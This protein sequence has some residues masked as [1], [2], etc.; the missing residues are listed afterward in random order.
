MKLIRPTAITDAA[1]TSSD[2][3][4]PESG[5]PTWLIGTTY[6]VGDHVTKGHRRYES[7][8]SSNVGH[9]PTS[10]ASGD[11]G[12]WNDLGP[13]NRWAMFD[14]SVGTET[15]STGSINVVLE[16]GTV[17]SLVVLDT[18]A[19][20]VTVSMTV[21]GS[22]V[23]ESEQTTNVGGAAI[24]DWFLYFFEPIGTKDTLSFTDLPPYASGVITVAITGRDPMGPVHV[25][26]LI[27]GR[28]L[29]IGSTEVGG[30]VGIT[31]YSK[32]VTDDFG[33]TT[34][35][36]RA[37][38][39]RMD[40]TCMLDTANVDAIQRELAKVRAVP[41][42]WIGEEGFDSLTIYG[43]YKDFSLNLTYSNISYCSLT[44]EGLT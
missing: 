31:D 8:V 1:L 35:V 26:T 6:A 16:P 25:G 17:D 41:C 19:E 12:K 11:I 15:T 3:A 22:P 13:T 4:E 32:K 21:S 20:V 36:E 2:Q 23:Y 39:K 42:I 7:L 10:T 18:D 29:E 43:F 5:Y 24:I 27:V 34:V 33:V 30:S 28:A 44:I 14:A 9:D 40:L 37:W 38:S